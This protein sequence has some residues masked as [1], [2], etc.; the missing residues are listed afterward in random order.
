MKIKASL[1]PNL[2]YETR[3]I[4]IKTKTWQMQIKN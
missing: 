3:K 1:I 2:D 4:K